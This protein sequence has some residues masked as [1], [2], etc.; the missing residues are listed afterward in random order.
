MAPSMYHESE[1]VEWMLTRPRDL[2]AERA[3]EDE[4]RRQRYM[5]CCE[6]KVRGYCVLLPASFFTNFEKDD[7]IMN[8]GKLAKCL[9]EMQRRG[10]DIPSELKRATSV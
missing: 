1:V 3:V 9:L 8:E 5:A 7:I 4:R 2:A 10:M 6:H